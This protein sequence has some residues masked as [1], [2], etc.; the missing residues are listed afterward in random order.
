[1]SHQYCPITRLPLPDGFNIHPTLTPRIRQ[2]LQ[3]IRELHPH[4]IDTIGGQ[5]QPNPPNTTPTGTSPRNPINY[6]LIE[7]LQLFEEDLIKISHTLTNH[8]TKTIIQATHL[9][10]VRTQQ[11][12]QNP[13]ARRHYYQIKHA[14]NA[15]ERTLNPKH[16]PRTP[17]TLTPEQENTPLPL[18]LAIQLYN[19]RNPTPINPRTLKTM[20]DRRLIPLGN[21]MVTQTQLSEAHAQIKPRRPKP[22]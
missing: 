14:R 8:P 10:E 12:C 20:K 6:Q 1:M 9:I 15:L 4:V 5:T 16:T 3:Q 13:N 22:T 11:L 2:N 21:P 7:D 19:T 17:I 18:K